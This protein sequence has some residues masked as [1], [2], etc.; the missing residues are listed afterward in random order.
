[1]EIDLDEKEH[2]YDCRKSGWTYNFIVRFLIKNKE[3]AECVVREVFPEF[4]LHQNPKK[5][6]EEVKG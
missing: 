3:L 1:M 2:R 6:E 4:H 5:K